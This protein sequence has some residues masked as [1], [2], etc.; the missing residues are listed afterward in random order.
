[1]ALYQF[2]IPCALWQELKREELIRADAPVP[3]N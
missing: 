1:M 3:Q 2:D